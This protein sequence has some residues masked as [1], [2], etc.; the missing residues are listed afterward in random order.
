[1]WTH[2]FEVILTGVGIFVSPLMALAGIG[3]ALTLLDRF[4]HAT[5]SRT[6]HTEAR[7]LFE[8]FG[9]THCERALLG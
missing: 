6:G 2:L 5:L 3:G 4:F 7:D 8:G 1:M 9:N